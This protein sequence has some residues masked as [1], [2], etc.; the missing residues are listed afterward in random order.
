MRGDLSGQQERCSS[1]VRVPLV[2][3][4][5]RVSIATDAHVP[6]D[7]QNSSRVS[8]V[9]T[10]KRRQFTRYATREEFEAEACTCTGTGT[11]DEQ[12]SQQVRTSIWCCSIVGSLWPRRFTS[13]MA[14][15]LFSLL[16]I[17][18][19]NASHTLPSATSPSPIRQY[20]R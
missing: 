19:M 2:R 20:T 8:T 1:M 10:V 15:R 5:L 14:T 17:A 12:R 7:R 6:P 16:C 9:P 11:A 3:S 13:K 18:N 4:S